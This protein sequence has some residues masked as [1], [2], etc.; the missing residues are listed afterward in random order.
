MDHLSRGQYITIS[1]LQSMTKFLVF[2]ELQEVQME[3]SPTHEKE[4]FHE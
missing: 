1:F 4:Y 3:I 2:L